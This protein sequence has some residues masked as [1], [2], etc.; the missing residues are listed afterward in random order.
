MSGHQKNMKLDCGAAVIS[1]MSKFFL[2]SS[3]TVCNIHFN[4]CLWRQ[5]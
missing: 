3:I 5:L 2:D 1:E 4:Q